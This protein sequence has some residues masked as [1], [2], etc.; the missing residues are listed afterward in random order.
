M[1]D[2]DDYKR[3]EEKGAE[4]FRRWRNEHPAAARELEEMRGGTRVEDLDAWRERYPD[5]VAE[6]TRAAIYSRDCVR[7]MRMAVPGW[8]PPD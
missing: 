6:Y 5:A 2:E 1:S 3:L 7:K 8:E 4:L